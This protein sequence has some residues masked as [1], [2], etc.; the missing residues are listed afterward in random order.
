MKQTSKPS[1][2]SSPEL[3]YCRRSMEVPRQSN[4]SRQPIHLKGYGLYSQIDNSF[5]CT[6]KK[7][8]AV[9]ERRERERERERERWKNI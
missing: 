3:H 7:R 5:Q 4:N 2:I 9:L 6:F 8:I 1:L